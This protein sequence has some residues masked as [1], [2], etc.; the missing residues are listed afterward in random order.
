MPNQLQ[1]YNSFL[2]ATDLEPD[3]VVSIMLF[4][5]ALNRRARDTTAPVNVSFLVGEG[6]SAVKVARMQKMLEKYKA[7]GLLTR[8]NVSVIQ[9][10]SDCYG[11]QRNFSADG[12]EILSAQELELALKSHPDGSK[13]ET[14]SAACEKIK[15]FLMTNA[16]TLVISLKPMRE[17]QDVYQQDQSV[18][19]Q[20][21]LACT[22]SYNF[23][24]ICWSKDMNE[25][26]RLQDE[27]LKLC[28]A[29]SVSFIYE[30]Y[31]TTEANSTSNYNSPAFFDL[32]EKAADDD[33]L[34]SLKI[35]I[36]NWTAHLLADDRRRL[37]ELLAK[38]NGFITPE[39]SERFVSLLNT[40]YTEEAWKLLRPVVDEGQKSFA[41]NKEVLDVF[42]S[43]SR[44]LGK[45]KSLTQAESQIVNAD[46]GLIAVLAGACDEHINLQPAKFGFQGAYTALSPPDE[47][48]RTHVYLPGKDTTLEKYLGWRQQEVA[49]K[50]KIAELKACQEQLLTSI[51]RAIALAGADIT[52]RTQLMKTDMVKLLVTSQ[53]RDLYSNN[54]VQQRVEEPAI[55]AQFSA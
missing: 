54:I 6:N 5:T 41:N 29:F 26:A 52:E 21:T 35:A 30:T 23:R 18:F 42:Q 46:P 2:Y 45:W 13:A 12:K 15:S 28:N 16:N 38:L 4:L 1:K 3:D 9:G 48:T 36:Q 40:N 25:E 20:H 49:T 51:N 39:M 10:Y 31:S 22:G 50:T 32:V 24:S 43:L 34:G 33:L 17:L 44:L 37:P 55:K 53:N 14:K 47:N 27:L 11:S 8:V 19:K 7:A